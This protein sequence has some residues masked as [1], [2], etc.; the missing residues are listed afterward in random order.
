MSY[1]LSDCLKN[2]INST[3][4]IKFGE[5]SLTKLI[6]R[7]NLCSGK[8]QLEFKTSKP[9]TSFDFGATVGVSRSEIRA[10]N[11]STSYEYLADSYSSID[12]TFG[13]MI[14]ISSPRISDKFTLQSE[15]HF[16]KSSYSNLVFL[17]GPSNRYHETY[18]DLTTLSIPLS[19]K[20]SFPEKTF[21]MY[22]QSGINYDYHINSDSRVKTETVTG[23]VVASFSERTAFD[24]SDNQI[25]FWGGIGVSK[26][27]KKIQGSI[28]IR[29]FQMLSL[30]NTGGYTVNNNRISLN[31]ILF[32][33]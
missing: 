4:R 12:P 5:K 25:G 20:Y 24:I 2:S 27:Y 16:S 10:T 11:Q 29:Y 30:N 18:I 7:Y 22:V 6:V 8:E 19:F 33:K 28:A 3:A 14:E 1:L 23:N 26:S 31:L 17:S 32:K 21:G 9:W 13:L 15:I